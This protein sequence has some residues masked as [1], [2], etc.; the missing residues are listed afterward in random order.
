[1]NENTFPYW[2]PYVT[3]CCFCT[4]HSDKMFAIYL[5]LYQTGF[6]YPGRSQI[7]LVYVTS[8]LQ[9]ARTYFPSGA[10]LMFDIYLP[11]TKALHVDWFSR[12][13]HFP[14]VPA[15][16]AADSMV[17]PTCIMLTLK[18]FWE[19]NSRVSSMLALIWKILW[20]GL[21]EHESRRWDITKFFCGDAH[22]ETA[23]CIFN[24]NQRFYPIPSVWVLP[25]FTCFILLN[26]SA[27]Y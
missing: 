15:S 2:L 26:T 1:M 6:E 9:W 19:N 21:T 17:S 5:G 20:W 18:L 16:S 10:S 25:Y 27:S 7:L 13:D 4:N 12:R 14:A 11:L 8:S 23:W 22:Q 3:R 24:I